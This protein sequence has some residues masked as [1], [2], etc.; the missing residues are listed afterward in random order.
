MMGLTVSLTEEA[1]R[2]IGVFQGEEADGELMQRKELAAN[3]QCILV[4]KR[5]G[6]LEGGVGSFLV[7]IFFLQLRQEMAYL[8]PCPY[9]YW[10]CCPHP[11]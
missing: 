9:D 2:L 5:G 1:P 3:P 11:L 7:W 4:R 8:R 6:S 10:I